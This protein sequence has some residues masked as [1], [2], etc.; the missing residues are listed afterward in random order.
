MIDPDELKCGQIKIK[1]IIFNKKTLK[2]IVK[3]GQMIFLLSK[4]HLYCF[5]QVKPHKQASRFFTGQ[6]MS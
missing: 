4:P 5:G 6:T 3:N 1:T 2:E